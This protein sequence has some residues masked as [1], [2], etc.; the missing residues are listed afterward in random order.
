MR[1]LTTLLLSLLLTAV[2]W[3]QRADP[4]FD[5]MGSVSLAFQ[6]G[7]VVLKV[8]AGAHLKASFMEVAKKGGPGTV[9][10][11]PMPATDA[12][13]EIGDGIWHG[14]VR[15]PVRGEGLAGT[16]KLE[17][18][19]QPCTEGEG[20]VCFPPTTRTLEVKASEIPA[21]APTAVAA[22]KP[23]VSP[24]E[25]AGEVAAPVVV[26]PA[27][28]PAPA[29]APEHSGL[30]WSL[31]VV[32]LFGMGA[33]FTP[34][35]YPMIPITMAI[36][37]AK[38]SGKARGFALSLALV[39]G[40]A[41]T[42]TALGVLAARAGSAAGAWAQQAAFLIP[43]S[44]LFAAFALSL[45]GAYEISLPSGLAMKLQG[46]GSRKGLSG[47][48]FMGM[49]LG[50]LSAPCVGPIIGSV[51]VDIAQKGEVFLGGL[52]LFVFALGMGVLFLAVGTFSA[53]LPKSGEWL[54][55]FKQGMGLVVLGFAAWNVRL[56][57]PDWANFAMW[58]VVMLA[59]AAV[60]GAF[61]AAAGLMGQL[62][63]GT[64]LLLLALALLL[65]V[66]TVETYLKVDLLPKGGVA[67]AAREEHAGWMEQDLE[68]AL[69]KAKVE[70]K[71]VLVDI[72]ADWCAQCKELD[73]K[74]WPDPALKQWVAQNAVPIRIDTDARRKD[75]ATKLQIRSYP[76]VLLL[77]AE[78]RE[79]RRILGFQKPE[80]M[81]A[82][83]EGKS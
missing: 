10:I 47:A 17:V 80:T 48:F 6:K 76:T 72:Y 78:G 4:A 64:A 24:V 50:P 70:H 79:L 22:E 53:A 21:A 49:V 38:G 28:T 65:G 51:L 43:V 9:K 7:A 20:G 13:D 31:L 83:L 29:P 23:A 41:V 2:A 1:S 71:L 82:W 57:V 33:S 3:A 34:C 14:T 67:A 32:F 52:K 63:K 11:G 69:A 68:G 77:D 56:V 55:R 54:T 19:Y 40:M 8:P 42:Y 37:G 45:F 60:F 44:I 74:T 36:V 25:K 59:G 66:R 18:T 30:V 12:K 15:I 27:P 62:R 16:V 81:K 35:V 58:T 5:A 61:E 46:D 26:A 39:L 75:L 73:E